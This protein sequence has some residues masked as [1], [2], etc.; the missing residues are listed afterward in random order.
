MIGT[1]NGSP[2]LDRQE[3]DAIAEVFGSRSIPVASVK[4]AIGE[5]GASGAAGLIAGLLSLAGG[6]V[7]PTAGFAQADPALP[8]CVSSHPQPA[9][10]ATFLVNSVASG[11]TN[12]SVAVRTTAGRS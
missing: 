2:T 6:V 8:V 10:G 12:Y 3:A 1:A 11:G 4:G 9:R 7:L 5:S